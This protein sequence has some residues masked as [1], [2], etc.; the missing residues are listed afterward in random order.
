MNWRKNT[1]N[2][3]MTWLKSIRVDRILTVFMA[4][5]LLIITTACSGGASATTPDQVKTAD[6][7]RQ[8]VPS[9]AVTNEYKGGMNDYSDVDPRF[10]EKGV[11]TS[12]KGLVDNARR[13]IEEKSID[14]PQQ[15]VENYRSGTPLGERV[16][17][18]GED[19]GN[20]AEDV[21]EKAAKG[22]QENTQAA[23]EATQSSKRAAK[24]T[25]DAAQS[26]VSSDINS[27]Q[28]A[29]QDLGNA[30]KSKVSRDINRTQQALDDAADAI[31]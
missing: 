19:L 27:T 6:K 28:Q 15:Y 20:A 17:R 26:K 18:I 5:L 30:A 16:K 24:E 14:S 13:N 1:M 7:I 12:A 10:N 31:D 3:L 9:G 21:T 23:K 4:G 22:T 29:A 8:E 11:Q 2:K 25:A